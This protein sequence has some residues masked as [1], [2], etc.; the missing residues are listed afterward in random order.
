MISATTGAG[1]EYSK[2]FMLHYDFPQYATGETGMSTGLNRRMVG[3]GNLA[4]RYAIIVVKRGLISGLIYLV[5]DALYRI[6]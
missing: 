1:E 4:E 3:H 6:S 2:H 5:V